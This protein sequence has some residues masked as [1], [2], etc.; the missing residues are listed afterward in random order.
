MPN[1]GTMKIA[2]EWNEWL[3]LNRL[4]EI[5]CSWNNNERVC[6]A[7]NWARQTEWNNEW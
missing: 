3:I 4:F 1:T 6:V 7:D 2:D 5:K